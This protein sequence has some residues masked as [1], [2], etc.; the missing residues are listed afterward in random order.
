MGEHSLLSS[1]KE[2]LSPDGQQ[3]KSSSKDSTRRSNPAHGQL[4]LAA[5][6][7]SDPTPSAPAAPPTAGPRA[8]AAPR[9]LRSAA[10]WGEAGAHTPGTSDPCVRDSVCEG[11]CHRPTDP[12]GAWGAAPASRPLALAA[13]LGPR[14]VDT[15]PRT[16][17]PWARE[18]PL[19]VRVGLCGQ[20]SLS[21]KDSRTEQGTSFMA[22]LSRVIRRPLFPNKA[23]PTG[24]R[25]RTPRG[26]LLSDAS[27]VGRLGEPAHRRTG[28]GGKGR[29]PGQS[30]GEAL[31]RGGELTLSAH[32]GL[33]VQTPAGAGGP[34]GR[35]QTRPQCQAL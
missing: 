25:G 35:Q 31:R 19:P 23:G 24:P 3:V 4:G 34:A 11:R 30:P 8:L 17:N 2:G 16:R 12:R 29:V 10:R 27:G 7:G 20:S 26:R 18:R 1:A 5:L 9:C 33:G 21:S 14:L 6:P 22:S 15:T 28:G 13:V 32:R